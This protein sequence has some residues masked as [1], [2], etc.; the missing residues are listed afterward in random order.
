MIDLNQHR[1]KIYEPFAEFLL[2]ADEEINFELSLLDTVRLSGHACP[3]IVGAFFLCQEAI[4]DL[5]PH[6]QICRRGEVK[7]YHSR[8]MGEGPTGPISNVFGYIMGGWGETGFPGL[9]EKFSRKGLQEFGCKDIPPNHFLFEHLPSGRK[10]FLEY[11]L[12]ELKKRLPPVDE[13]QQSWRHLISLVASETS[14]AIKRK[15]L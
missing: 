8:R 14:A 11:D 1:I 12:S 3:S 9:G 4:R 15:A 5:F 2:G 10:S 6:D 7:I 13:F